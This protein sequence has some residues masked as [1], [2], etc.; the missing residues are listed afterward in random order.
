MRI[1]VESLKR[2]YENDRVTKA[3]LQ[4][5]VEKGIISIDEY[6]YIVGEDTEKTENEKA[7]QSEE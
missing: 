4:K 7:E 3:Q 1:L 6:N 5:R 2:L